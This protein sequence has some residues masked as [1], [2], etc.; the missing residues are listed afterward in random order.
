MNKLLLL[1]YTLFVGF[2]S[3]FSQTVQCDSVFLSN[4]NIIVGKAIK[5][6]PNEFIK[7]RTD[8]GIFV[9][10]LEDTKKL[11]IHTVENYQN[12]FDLTDQ[13]DLKSSAII[14]SNSKDTIYY[15]LTESGNVHRSRHSHIFQLETGYD[16]CK[17]K[18]KVVYN[19]NV[20]KE[21]A[22]GF[23]YEYM[24]ILD[25]NEYDNLL[26]DFKFPTVT[27][28]NNL[29][30]FA[31]NLGIGVERI[32]G[33]ES[34]AL[35]SLNPSYSYAFRIDGNIFFSIGTEMTYFIKQDI[36]AI[37]LTAGFLF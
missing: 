3:T 29:S 7:I 32:Y 31:V 13:L 30:L 34:G 16:L 33:L 10:N 6:S 8:K 26:I 11:C 1:I 36:L 5:L 25:T 15:V 23:G 21:F 2:F 17:F 28:S 12:G 35:W 37:G 4:G 14:N 18:A 22:I 9:F 27:S 20:D 24:N 19:F